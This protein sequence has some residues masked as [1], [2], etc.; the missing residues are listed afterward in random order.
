VDIPLKIRT[1]SYHTD[2]GD[3]ITVYRAYVTIEFR[4]H[5]GRTVALP[6]MIDPG[7]PLSVVPHQVWSLQKLAW[8]SV[9]KTLT[10][11]GRSSG[12]DWLGVPCEL[13]FA[14]VELAGSRKLVAKFALR[15]TLL[16]DIILGTNFL[17]DNDI[18][19]VLRGLNGS[20]SGFLSVS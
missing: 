14:E 12:I 17:T 11:R 13:G 5:A 19:L 9:S 15:P 2:Q 16:G 7:A 10:R 6:G 8:S 3:T 4:D 18:E 1:A 20:L